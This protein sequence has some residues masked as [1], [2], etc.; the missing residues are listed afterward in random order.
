M[1]LRGGELV[2]DRS[3]SERFPGDLVRFSAASSWLASSEPWLLVGLGLSGLA[4]GCAWLCASVLGC[5]GLRPMLGEYGSSIST[6]GVRLTMESGL[7]RPGAVLT[8]WGAP[9]A[10]WA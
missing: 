10:C 3:A 5:G 7:L 9:P 1:R 8:G 4:G 2:G 6:S